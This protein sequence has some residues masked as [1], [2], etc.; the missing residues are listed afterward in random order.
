MNEMNL[1]PGRGM[2][3]LED[4]SAI[5]LW[6]ASEEAR[7]MTDYALPFDVGFLTR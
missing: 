1:L 7:L 4:I 2:L 5:I 6:L 3:A